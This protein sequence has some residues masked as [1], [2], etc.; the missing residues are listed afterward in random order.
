M[1]MNRVEK[2]RWHDRLATSEWMRCRN[3]DA[4]RAAA[5]VRGLG[6]AQLVRPALGQG[7]S[8]SRCHA[9]GIQDNLG[10][11]EIARESRAQFRWRVSR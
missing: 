8:L 4:V 2:S 7:V 3:G 9:Q 6:V 10:H 1:E 11:P 5:A